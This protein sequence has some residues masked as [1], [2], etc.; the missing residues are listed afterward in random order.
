[1]GFAHTNASTLEKTIEDMETKLKSAAKET[2]TLGTNAQLLT[3]DVKSFAEVVGKLKDD[4]LEQKLNK[5][6]KIEKKLG[7]FDQQVKR[8]V[9]AQH[10]EGDRKKR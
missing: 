3:G 4:G 8:A 2:A 7:S 5:L 6:E 10:S 1:M 9:K